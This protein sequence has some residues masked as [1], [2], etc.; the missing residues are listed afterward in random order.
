MKSSLVRLA[1]S[2]VIPLVS[3]SSLALVGCDSD[4]EGPGT[5]SGCAKVGDAVTLPPALAFDIAAGAS[6]YETT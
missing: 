3:A 5:T 4:S 1:R 2:C 6:G